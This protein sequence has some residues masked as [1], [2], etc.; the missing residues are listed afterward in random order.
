MCVCVCVLSWLLLHCRFP[1]ACEQCSSVS[2]SVVSVS[3]ICGG[4]GGGG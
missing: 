3:K 4:G 2:L 1:Q